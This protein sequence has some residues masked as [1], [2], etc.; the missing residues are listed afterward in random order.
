MKRTKMRLTGLVA[1]LVFLMPAM[2]NAATFFVKSDGDD[3]N[4]GSSWDNAKLTIA[5]AFSAASDGDDI[6]VGY[7][8]S[9]TTTYSI[10]SS[11]AISG[12]NMRITSARVN[13][14]N[15]Y[16]TADYDSSK[17]IIDAGN[18]RVF[19]ITG[20]SVTTSTRIRGFKITGGDGRYESTGVDKGGGIYIED[21]ADPVI[22]YNWVTGNY[23]TTDWR[24]GFGGGIYMSNSSAAIQ[25][26][27]IS[28]NYG[29]PWVTGYSGFGGGIYCEANTGSYTP[30]IQ[31]NTISS[32]LAAPRGNGKGGGIDIV[33]GNIVDAVIKGNTISSNVACRKQSSAG[34]ADGGGI[35][36]EADVNI[37]NNTFSGNTTKGESPQDGHGSAICRWGTA[38]TPTIKNNIFV[39]HNTTDLPY[40]D[41]VAIYSYTSGQ[42]VSYSCFYN[43][44]TNTYQCSESNTF[45]ANPWF[46]NAA[47]GDFT[48]TY[49]SPCID[50]GES[51]YTYNETENHDKGWKVDIGAEEYTGTRVKKTVSETGELLF[52]GKVRGKVD[53]TTQGSLSAIDITVYPGETRSNAPASVQRYFTIT[54]TGSGYQFDITL[55]YK[56]SEL[57]NETEGSLKL[58]RWTGSSWDGPKSSSTSST[59]NNW[60]KVTG[61]SA[62]SDWVISDAEDDTALPVGLISFTATPGDGQVTLKWV[63]ESERDNLGFTIYRSLSEKRD[64][65]RI[66]SELIP[67]AG[68]SAYRNEYEYV[69]KSL[70]NG[71]TYWY[72]LEDVDY[73][74]NTSL[75]GSVSATPTAGIHPTV[76][77]LS[78]NYPNP[79]NPL[80]IIR[81]QIPEDGKVVLGIYNLL[82]QPIRTLVDKEQEAGDYRVEWDGRDTEGARVGSGIY[83]YR[84]KTNDFVQVKKMVL[85]D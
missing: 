68:N 50:A 22:E 55:S 84:L 82:G 66:T 51:S 4:D 12:K 26:N 77:Q 42:P 2:I 83:F 38:K 43:N 78:Q 64:Y 54:P 45:S 1:F 74:G 31:Y 40:S 19:T 65:Q 76:F 32:N 33:G 5:G 48:L 18:C 44:T 62:F 11:I 70:T 3:G 28:D 21:G 30:T 57:N 85:L 13:Q 72:K 36:T 75:H 47:G 24:T 7:D 52:G 60:L 9:G 59:D 56:D 10:T 46:T 58:W 53:V 25:Y 6:L 81:Y 69:D 35:Y 79:F 16:A 49:E 37:V 17:C 73:D 41:G 14:D 8:P 63:T 71:V 27:N 23:S 29:G 20:A 15:S 61:Q 67:G 39:D 34:Y 80:T